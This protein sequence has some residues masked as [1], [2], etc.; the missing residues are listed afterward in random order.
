MCGIHN[1]VISANRIQHLKEVILTSR[2]QVYSRLVEQKDVRV[3]GMFLLAG[4]KNGLQG[5]EVSESATSPR[6]TYKPSTHGRIFY[7]QNDAVGF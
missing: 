6:C 4:V 5:E 7:A 1:L 3:R 2:V